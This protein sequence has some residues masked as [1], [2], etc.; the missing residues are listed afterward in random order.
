MNHKEMLELLDYKRRVAE[1]YAAVRRMDDPAEAW[2][3]WR[4]RR[5]WLF[6][7]HPQS[8]LPE[9]ER[10]TAG[11][12]DY[13]PY[14]PSYRVSAEI[15]GATATSFE[16]PSSQG[17]TMTFTRTGVAEFNLGGE[18]HTL[19]LFWL[20]EYGGGLFLPFKD[21]TSGKET[22]GGGRYLLDTVKGA[23]LGSDAAL[24]YQDNLLLDFNFA[25]N[26]SCSYNPTWACPLS[27]PSNTLNIAVRAGEKH[28][29]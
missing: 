1:M 5:D 2:N 15:K 11:R 26:P 10:T 28:R 13:F 29:T 14:D 8:A 24:G 4:E 19:D 18:L 6:A 9:D 21:D 22:Y 3:L 23:D 27:P 25:Y 17:Q 16:I 12:L 20:E 7:E